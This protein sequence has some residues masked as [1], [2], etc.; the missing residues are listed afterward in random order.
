M[1]TGVGIP[2]NHS[3]IPWPIRNSSTERR[4]CYEGRTVLK[5]N[6]N[7]PEVRGRFDFSGLRLIRPLTVSC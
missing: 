6:E 7:A 4:D 3:R 2:K 1:I 5:A